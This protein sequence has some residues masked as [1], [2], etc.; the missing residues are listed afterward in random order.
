MLKKFAAILKDVKMIVFR[1]KK[2]KNC[3]LCFRTKIKL[4]KNV[5]NICVVNMI[6]LNIVSK[7]LK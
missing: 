7:G 2:K 5:F 6:R 1:Y 3:N 4:E